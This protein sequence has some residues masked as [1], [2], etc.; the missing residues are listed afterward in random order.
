MEQVKIRKEIKFWN[1]IGKYCVAMYL[2]SSFDCWFENAFHKDVKK[3]EEIVLE[4]V[5]KH[6]NFVRE[7]KRASEI[8]EMT[9]SV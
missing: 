3:A 4:K 8:S 9:I 7:M 6:I 5:K 1:E 2:D